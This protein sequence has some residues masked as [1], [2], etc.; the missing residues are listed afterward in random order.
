[1]SGIQREIEAILKLA[2]SVKNETVFQ[3]K[4]QYKKFKAKKI[5]GH[6]TE[7]WDFCLELEKV[8]HPMFLEECIFWWHKLFQ[9]KVCTKEEKFQ[10]F[11][12]L[13]FCYYSSPKDNFEMCIEYGQK[14]LDLQVDYREGL[15]TKSQHMKMMED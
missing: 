5:G 13:S 1:M 2:K 11:R 9:E 15:E 6:K 4:T 3:E 10:I 7:I 14:A 8:Q 12:S